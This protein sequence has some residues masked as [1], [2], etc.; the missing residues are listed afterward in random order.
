ML[1]G[2]G[3][4]NFSLVL[5]QET[6]P[7]IRT[8][9][10]SYDFILGTVA[11]GLQAAG[12]PARCQGTSDIAVDEWKISGNA[13]RRRKRCILHHGTLLYAAD[14][15]LIPRYIKEP[16]DRPEYRGERRHEDFV[17][18]LPADRDALRM[19][20]RETF[21]GGSDSGLTKEEQTLLTRLREEK[22]SRKEWIHRR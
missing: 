5:D 1:Q 17:R 7:S 14:L 15:G 22:Y 12:I 20:L 2:P 8:I 16:A 11:R 10:S 3:C 13:Q 18:N 4:L 21:R 9:R 19:H 6:R